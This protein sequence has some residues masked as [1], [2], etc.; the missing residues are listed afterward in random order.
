MALAPVATQKEV[1]GQV[2][3]SKPATPRVA[4][5]GVGIAGG[6]TPADGD[7]VD[8]VVEE[9]VVVDGGEV[10]EL[11]FVVGVGLVVGTVTTEEDGSDRVDF[12][13]CLTRADPPWALKTPYAMPPTPQMTT[14]AI[15]AVTCSLVRN[16]VRRTLMATGRFRSS[17]SVGRCE[18]LRALNVLAEKM[19]E[20]R[21]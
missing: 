20:R 6:P 4:P 10:V 15:A 18:S 8:V 17:V 3:A 12:S 16:L 7:E 14:T 19:L 21:S 1:V 13:G 5:P 9:G 2:T 11:G